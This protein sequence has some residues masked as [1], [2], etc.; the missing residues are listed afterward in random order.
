MNAFVRAL[1]I[2]AVAWS[3]GCGNNSGSQIPLSQC[4]SGWYLAPPSAA[5][6]PDLCGSMPPAE[7]GFKDCT[8]WGFE[9]FL[10]GGV[11]YVGELFYSAQSMSMSGSG[12]K[13]T[14]VATSDGYRIAGAETITVDSCT[15]TQLSAEKDIVLTRPPANLAAALDQATSGGATTFTHVAVAQ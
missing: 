6:T 15:S 3:A 4:V 5:C 2:A 11:W 13:N 7:C 9:G 12:M 10:P 8:G 1:L 14:W